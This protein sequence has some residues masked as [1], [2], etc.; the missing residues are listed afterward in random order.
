MRIVLAVVV[1]LAASGRTPGA[2]TPGSP[3][4]EKPNVL[5]ISIDDLNDWVGPLGGH[6][7]VKT[8]NMDRLAARGTTFTNAH[9]QSP[10]CNPSRTSILTGLRPTTTGVYALAP[11]FRTSDKLKDHATIFQ[12]FH[13]QGYT[14]LTGGKIFHD[15]YPP[16][17]DKKDAGPEVDVWGTHG[18]FT[19]RPKT[20]FVTTP[21]NIAL[22]DW[23]AF[24]EKDEECYDY[25]VATWAVQQLKSPP[26]G[27]FFLAVGFRHPHVPCYAPQKWFDLYPE[28]K[29]V[30]PPVKAD[31]RDDLPRFA[32]YLHW[33]LPEPRLKW[34]E[35][36]KQWKPLVRSYLASISYVDS[37]VGRVL[38][39][40]AASGLEKNTVIVLWSDHGWHLGEKGITGKN[41]LW[42][43]STRVPLIFAGPGITSGV[44]CNR[45]AELLD[46]YPTLAELA[47]LPANSANEGLSL[48]PQL[49]D[50]KAARERPAITT[51]NAGNHGIRTEQWRYIRYAD[52]SEE[53]YDVLADPNEWTNIAGDA[54]HADTKKQLARWLPAKSAAPL[55]GSA[56]RILTYENGV[57]VWEGKPIGKNDPF[58]EK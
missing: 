6:P 29:L 18:G 22:M 19:P 20:K 26:K 45:P 21:D 33:K 50:V 38:E 24:P 23:G 4:S 47:G 11:W 27:P 34:L 32:S 58:P 28:D 40:L 10:L 56:G 57:P 5:F 51:H 49:K 48:F 8:P 12:W 46:V 30:M 41:T 14:T 37:Q 3:K 1:I 35:E 42:E 2:D 17:L 15:A 52:G 53:L 36:S 43:R 31:D 7:Q 9:C 54:K 44:K 25:D 55:P 16:K 39:A 13:K